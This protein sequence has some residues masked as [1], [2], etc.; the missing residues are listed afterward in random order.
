MATEETIEF[1]S[2]ISL[3]QA[4]EFTALAILESRTPNST[5]E[6]DRPLSSFFVRY[7]DRFPNGTTFQRM[8]LFGG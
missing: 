1:V 8:K 7:L 4:N 5:H 3:G 6:Y 2:E